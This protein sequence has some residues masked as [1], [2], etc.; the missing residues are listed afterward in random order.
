MV[1]CV[2]FYPAFSKTVINAH[3]LCSILMSTPMVGLF[4]S[5][6]LLPWW[7]TLSIP[8]LLRREGM[9]ALFQ[10]Y[11]D[12]R[13]CSWWSCIRPHL[14]HTWQTFSLEPFAIKE[15]EPENRI[16]IAWLPKAQSRSRPH[17]SLPFPAFSL[18]LSIPYPL[19][20][21]TSA[22]SMELLFWV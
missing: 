10:C 22:W 19:H 2:T 13:T 1:L 11:T 6:H 5:C 21:H 3:G 16:G 4:P 20:T 15:F 9:A 7:G 14:P 18:F 12:I 8:G 17:F